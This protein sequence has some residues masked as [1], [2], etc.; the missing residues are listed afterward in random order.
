[1][2]KQTIILLIA[3]I[4]IVGTSYAYVQKTYVS[5]SVMDLIISRLDRIENK[6]DIII[7]D[8]SNW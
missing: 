5:K 3:L 6:V 8:R 1:M 2:N 4:T 7:R